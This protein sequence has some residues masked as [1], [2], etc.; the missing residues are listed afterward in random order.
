M[1]KP[2]YIE[3]PEVM[4]EYFEEYKKWVSE[5]PIEV[6][7]FVGKDGDEVF[8]K[9]QRPMT[10]E[11][12]ELFLFEKEIINDAGDYFSNKE[13]RYSEYAAICSRIK[14]AIRNDHITGGMVGIYKESITQRI[15]GIADKTQADDKTE[16]TV[17]VKYERK[18]TDGNT[19]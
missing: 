5:N 1:A 11:G 12:F 4:W 16:I 9:R 6:Q 3:T 7:D 13:G 17:K 8:R 2:K 15:N 19:E 10:M 14:K 18:G